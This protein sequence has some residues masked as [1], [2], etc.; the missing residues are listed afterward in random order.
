MPPGVHGFIFDEQADHF[1]LSGALLGSPSLGLSW[2]LLVS[3]GFVLAL[4]G[5][6]GSSGLSRDLLCSSGVVW[7][8]LGSSGLS[9]AL[10]GSSGLSW[11]LLVSTGFVLAL[12]G[13]PG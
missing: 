8:L 1:G 7:A 6:P 13:F 5:F 4:L 2:A 3:T 12:L 10:L 11:A 9:W